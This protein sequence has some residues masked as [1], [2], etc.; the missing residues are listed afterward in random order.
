MDASALV[1]MVVGMVVIWGG[2]AASV[3]YAVKKARS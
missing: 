1:M 3:L 2:L